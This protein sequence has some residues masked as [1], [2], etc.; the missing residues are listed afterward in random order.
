MSYK[1]LFDPRALK[2]WNKL[3]PEIRNQFKKKLDKIL[4]N[5]R[6]EKNKLSDLKD[7]YKIK[8]RTVGYRLVYKVVDD[9]LIVFVISVG[10]RER[11]LVYQEAYFRLRQPQ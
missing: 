4:E 5:P 2:A 3:N 10:K 7:C 1:L 11:G 6:I 9:Q 8:L